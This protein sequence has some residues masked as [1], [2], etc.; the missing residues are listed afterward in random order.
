VGDQRDP[1]GSRDEDGS[2]PGRDTGS[3]GA[4]RRSISGA[5]SLPGGATT[6]VSHDGLEPVESAPPTEDGPCDVDARYVDL[7]LL[8]RGG[9]GEVRLC[10]D[11]QIGRQIALKVIR[12]SRASRARPRARFVRE[13]KIQGQ[14][15]HPAVVPVYDFGEGADGRTYFTMRQVF[16][17]TLDEIIKSTREGDPLVRSD[18]PRARLLDAFVRVCLAVDYI[19][20]SGVLH[21]DLK[22]SNVMLGRFGEVYI[23]DWGLAKLLRDGDDAE[24]ADVPGD[25]SAPN[26][27]P[28]AGQTAAGE[29]MGTPGYMAPEQLDGGMRPV[30]ERADIYAL[31][32][33]LFELLTG[34][35]LHPRDS[36]QR[37]IGST[38]RGANAR[39]NERAPDATVPPELEAVCVRATAD[40]PQDRYPTARALHD[41]VLA[42]LD[43]ER[44][45]EVRAQIA[46]HWA[47]RASQ[48]ATAVLEG[49]QSPRR[50]SYALEQAGRALALDPDNATARE[51]IV[52]L[53]LEP[54]HATPPQAL[55]HLQEAEREA[56]RSAA[57]GGVVGF[58]AWLLFV[59]AVVALGVRDWAMMGALLA[60]T[61]GALV[62]SWYGGRQ[63]AAHR[64]PR[65]LAFAFGMMGLAL[66]GRLFGPLIL[67]P[68]LAATTAA[69]FCMHATGRSRLAYLAVAAGVVIVP[70]GLELAGILEPSYVFA[71]DRMIITPHLT[72]LPQTATLT[73]LILAT[74]AA[75]VVPALLLARARDG[76]RHAERDLAIH[77]W[78]M[79]QLLPPSARHD[80]EETTASR[81]VAPSEDERDDESGPQPRRNRGHDG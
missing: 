31:G 40:D 5:W 18:Y 56:E 38:I 32:A 13:A 6:L 4:A 74:V 7:G 79:E 75:I 62:T 72:E 10:R 11:A 50:R 46:K 70:L 14:L 69:S 37:L 36:V 76:L 61:A 78:Q 60:V 41:A 71:G 22:P 52:R 16:G 49:D 33:V 9:M 21:R 67:V 24:D 30:D 59:P 44:D 25:D 17:R 51:T 80:F 15:E 34:Q 20:E 48:T 26:L 23:L 55:A 68:G 57:R 8:G 73:F 19:H 28:E 12:R 39:C 42:Y 63:R 47:E 58:A 81:R 45:V 43:G 35:P 53:L 1:E 77:A 54:P 66:V 64:W 65:A 2:R 3:P 27:E 29:L